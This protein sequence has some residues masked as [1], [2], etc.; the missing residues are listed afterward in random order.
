MLLAVKRG[1]EPEAETA[2]SLRRDPEGPQNSLLSGHFTRPDVPSTD[3]TP[4]LP[5]ERPFVLGLGD[6]F[7]PGVWPCPATRVLCAGERLFFGPPFPTT[8]SR[9]CV[10]AVGG[11]LILCGQ[12]GAGCWMLDFGC[13]SVPAPIA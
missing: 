7:Y 13:W 1:R 10:A 8:G 2:P 9:L 4:L 5:P 11:D 3:P 12:L 6:P